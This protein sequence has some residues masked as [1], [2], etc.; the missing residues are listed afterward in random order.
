MMLVVLGRHVPAFEIF[1]IMPL[2]DRGRGQTASGQA[3]RRGRKGDAKCR[4]HLEG[5]AALI[6]RKVV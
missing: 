1:D 3:D 4:R 5:D 6:L 2:D